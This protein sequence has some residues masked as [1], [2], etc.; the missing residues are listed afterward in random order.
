MKYVPVSRSYFKHRDFPL[1]LT[2]NSSEGCPTRPYDI[3]VMQETID[4]AEVD[5]RSV[6]GDVLDRTLNPPPS[7]SVDRV[8]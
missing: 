6:V 5:E 7:F 3:S 2:W 4:A 8:V 1:S